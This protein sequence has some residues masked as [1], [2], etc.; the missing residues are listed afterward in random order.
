LAALY[1]ES[2]KAAAAQLGKFGRLTL[3]LLV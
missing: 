1:G 3:Q 2:R